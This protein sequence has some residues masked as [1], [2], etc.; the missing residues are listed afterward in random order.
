[1]KTRI[2]AVCGVVLALLGVVDGQAP[3]MQKPAPEVKRLHYF[4]GTWTAA[5]E[6]KPGPMGPGG[7]VNSVD[8]SRM[9]PGGFF[10]ET[11]T[12]GGGAMGVVKSLAI[13]GYNAEEKVYTYDAFNSL[14]EADHFKGSVQGDTWTWNSE[15]MIAGKPTKLRFIAKEVSPTIYTM[16]FEMGTGDDWTTVMEGKA[17][18]KG[19]R[20]K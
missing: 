9:M 1:M 13:M 4:V 16:K 5:Y 7:K 14:G 17:T 20:T 11:R 8:Q 12:E 6:I 2:S 15:G 10:L 18:K 19:T 3:Q